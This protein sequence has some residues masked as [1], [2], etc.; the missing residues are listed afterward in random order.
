MDNDAPVKKQK[1][2]KKITKSQILMFFLLLIF[3]I[4]SSLQFR[5][6]EDNRK[7]IEAA[8]IDYKYY[9]DMLAAEHKYTETTAV[10]LD[11]L[12]DK[13]NELLKKLLL[14]SGD[15]AIL[16]SLQKVYK[17]AGFTDVTGKGLVVTLDDQSIKDPSFPATTSAIHDLDIRQ[18][19]DIMRSCGAVAISVNGERVVSTSELTCNGPTVQINKKKFPV[20]YKIAAIGDVVLMK[21]MIEKDTYIVNRILSN[22]Q[23]S[24]KIDEEL[25][26]KAF[27][28]YD[29]IDQ[30]IDSFKEVS[31]K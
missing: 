18:V 14:E 22:I 7:K 6:I 29:K 23:F 30:Y 11:E 13:K 15:T 16:D 31:T 1:I 3:G 24:I 20:P 27:S 12:K 9:A 4:V 5:A 10:K 17:I 26:I 2:K 21:T 25:T 19:V 8:K 28:D